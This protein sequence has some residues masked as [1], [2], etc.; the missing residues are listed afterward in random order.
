MDRYKKVEILTGETDQTVISLYFDIA[1]Q[2]ILEYTNRKE[3]LDVFAIKQLEL[4]VVLYER[5][6]SLGESNHNE[7]GISSTFIDYDKV[8]SGLNSYRLAR[9]GGVSHEK[10]QVEEV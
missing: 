4:A 7:G 5:S 3:F 10:K 2:K 9:A 1:Q 8:L 6:G